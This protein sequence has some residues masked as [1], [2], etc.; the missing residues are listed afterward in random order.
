[1]GGQTDSQVGSQVH[2]SPQKLYIS[3]IYSWPAINVCRLA[4]GGQMVK[5]FRRLA[6]EFELDQNQ[7]KSSQVLHASGWPNEKQVERK[8]KTCVELRRLESPFGQ[9]LRVYIF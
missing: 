1:M 8:S 9:S 3:R 6:Y 7:R 5:N 2:A 4:L